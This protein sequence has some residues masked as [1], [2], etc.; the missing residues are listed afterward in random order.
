VEK[1]AAGHTYICSVLLIVTLRH[2][3]PSLGII[4]YV[5]TRS[6]LQ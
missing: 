1:M 4:N 2:V 3:K 6:A 5:V